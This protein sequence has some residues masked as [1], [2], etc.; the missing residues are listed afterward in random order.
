MA[1]RADTE[2]SYGLPDRNPAL[3][4][5][6]QSLRNIDGE[7]SYQVYFDP[8]VSVTL[9]GH[10]QGIAR[11]PVAHG[12]P[13]FVMSKS[14]DGDAQHAGFLWVNHPA[15]SSLGEAFSAERAQGGPGPGKLAHFWGRSRSE[16][17]GGLQQCGQL[18]AVAQ[19]PE[20]GFS[21]VSLIDGRD[22]EHPAFLGRLLLD[23]SHGEQVDGITCAGLT[24]LADGHTLLFAYRYSATHPE[25]C[26]GHFFRSEQATLDAATTWQRIATL[27]LG[28]GLPANWQ[29]AIENVA[30]VNQRDG[31]IFLAALYGGVLTSHVDL[32]QLVGDEPALALERRASKTLRTMLGGGTL[33]A[34]GALHIT[35]TRKLVVYAVQKEHGDAV[36]NMLVEE[37]IG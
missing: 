15:S 31:S 1:L 10:I 20:N 9:H 32:Y 18:I 37:F 3:E 6:A 35:P 14:Q 8:E 28:S 7:Q 25:N 23:G 12:S 13:W 27:K 26:R 36:G 33:R 19:D 17:P 4:D 34:G 11:L 5:V 16:H 30:L 21:F 29:P 24:R 2:L 22:P